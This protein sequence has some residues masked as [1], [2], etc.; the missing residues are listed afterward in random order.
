MALALILLVTLGCGLV[1]RVQ[2]AVTE[3]ESN[4][5]SNVNSNKTLTDK[6]IE[7]AV[8]EGK[9]GIAECD[10]AID[11]LTA[12][13]NNPDDNFV[14]KAIKTTALN[15]LK[16]RVKQEIEKRNTNKTELAKMCREFKSNM[17][18]SVAEP[19]NNQ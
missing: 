7:T 3:S 11:F 2:N 18:S 8:G 16:E 4:S 17:E 1:G 15:T 13:A 14:T 9:T 5:D 6:A 10:E 19:A 12:Q